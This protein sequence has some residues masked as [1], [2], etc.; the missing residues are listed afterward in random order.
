MNIFRSPAALI[1]AA[2]LCATLGAGCFTPAPSEPVPPTEQP[3]M[4]LRG[5]VAGDAVVLEEPAGI[6]GGK[7][8]AGPLM[9]RVAAQSFTM[10]QSSEAAWELGNASNTKLATGSWTK[11]SLRTAHP[12]FLPA[13]FDAKSRPVDDASLLWLAQ[14]EYRELK[15]TSG[16]TIDLRVAAVPEWADRFKAHA[17]ASRGFAAFSRLVAEAEQ[18]RQDLPY[19]KLESVGER[20]LRV[21]GKEL[22][23]PV[24]R[25]RN[26]YGTFEVLDRAD[27]PLV[28][29]FALDPK[30]AK[31]RLDVTKGDGKA[32]ADLMNY[33]VKEIVFS[34]R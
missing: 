19:A 14:E 17:P 15:A 10:G 31:S 28:L 33:Q 18:A 21:N 12:F 6:I 9:R 27:N 3:S 22:Q 1:A 20:T 13:V 24:L 7:F 8:Q 23:A 16:T 5:I 34:G 4:G 30:V 32:L 26:W 2:A 29:S 11:A 25:V